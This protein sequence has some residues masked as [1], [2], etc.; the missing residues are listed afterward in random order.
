MAVV[1][2][3]VTEDGFQVP[4]ELARQL[5]LEPGEEVTVQ[6]RRAPDAEAVRNAALHYAWRRLGDAV[7]VEEPAW[8]GEVWTVPLK[9]RHQTGTFGQL[10]LSADGDVLVDRSTRKQ[11]LIEALDARRSSPQ[12]GG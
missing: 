8:D 1:R 12:A 6:V 3:R 2:V 9:I 10:V 7:G 11:D 4:S 5:G